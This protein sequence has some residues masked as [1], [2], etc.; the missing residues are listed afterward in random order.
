M[1]SQN[2][3]EL[4]KQGNPK[5]IA[6]LINRNLRP[7]GITAEVSREGDCLE[8]LLESEKV[9]SQEKLANYLNAG[10]KKKGV[11]GVNTLQISAR[12]IGNEI[13]SWTQTISLRTPQTSQESTLPVAQNSDLVEP[14]E[15]DAVNENTEETISQPSTFNAPGGGLILLQDPLQ[16]SKI[17]KINLNH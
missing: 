11:A 5:A 13:P 6:T 2:S 9:P 4:A 15:V 1:S 14:P 10:I 8:I 16:P 17:L 12:Q 7:K 3:Q